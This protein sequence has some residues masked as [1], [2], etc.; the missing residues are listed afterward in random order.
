MCE[1]E[2]HPLRLQ[3]RLR[4][5]TEISHRQHLP[6][7]FSRSLFPAPLNYRSYRELSAALPVASGSVQG[8]P[9]LH[10]DADPPLDVAQGSAR[11]R[12]LLPYPPPPSCRVTK[13][14]AAAFRA[15]RAAW[16]APARDSPASAPSSRSGSQGAANSWCGTSPPGDTDCWKPRKVT[17]LKAL[18]WLRPLFSN[19]C[20][21][22]GRGCIDV[23]IC[24]Y[25]SI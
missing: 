18:P 10:P 6:R 24:M 12:Q 17:R 7:I 21:I 9:S 20:R 2:L 8:A 22:K 13:Y 5:G 16:R 25:V 3:K 4:H 14:E 19:V 23:C 1:G 11:P 15:S